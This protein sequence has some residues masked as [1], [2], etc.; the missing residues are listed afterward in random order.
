MAPG[1][2]VITNTHRFLSQTFMLINSPVLTT[3][4][5]DAAELVNVFALADAR[6]QISL[7][8][9]IKSSF[10]RAL[11]AVTLIRLEKMDTGAASQHG[12]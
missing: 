4:R 9:Q 1:H 11:A 6:H 12:P 8:L 10:R 7:L 2:A 5:P 3:S